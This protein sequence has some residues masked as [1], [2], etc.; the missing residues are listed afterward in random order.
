MTSGEAKLVVPRCYQ[1][2]SGWPTVCIRIPGPRPAH[3]DCFSPKAFID[4]ELLADRPAVRWAGIVVQHEH[5]HVVVGR[6][7]GAVAGDAVELGRAD[8]QT[9]TQIGDC[10][11]RSS[12]TVE[13]DAGR[14]I[15][16]AVR[17]T[18]T[19]PTMT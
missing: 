4:V 14:A 19:M 17:V 7:A 15:N 16:K 5:G 6:P 10:P 9:A 3:S 11:F 1:L 18:T 2:V 8:P 12:A 13:V